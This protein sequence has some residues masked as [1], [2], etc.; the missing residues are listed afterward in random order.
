MSVTVLERPDT[1]SV[2]ADYD[3]HEVYRRHGFDAGYHQALIDLHRSLVVH[4]EVHLLTGG[5]GAEPRK[6]LYAFVARLQRALLAGSPLIGA[7]PDALTVSH[8]NPPLLD[9]AGI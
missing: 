8:P 9:G 2:S 3:L 1:D 7:G 4:A 5:G 6:Q